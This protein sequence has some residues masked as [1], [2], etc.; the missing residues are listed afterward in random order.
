MGLQDQIQNDMKDAMRSGDTLK[1][2]TL[3]MLIAAMKNEQIE[4]GERGDDLSEDSVLAVVRRGVKSRMD[5]ATQYRDAD[6]ADLAEKEESEIDVL[7]GYLPQMMSEDETAAAVDV[8]IAE[9]GAAG[10]SDM[11]KVMKAVMAKH[12]ALVDG[13]L[14]NRLAGQKL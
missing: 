7:D 14:V 13:K 1:R 11:G 6:R 5:S 4:R 10:K 12:G 9:T 8:A 2:D 3:R